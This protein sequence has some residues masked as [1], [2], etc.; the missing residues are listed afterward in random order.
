MLKRRLIALIVLLLGAGIGWFVYSSQ[1]S[2][3]RPFKLGLDLSGGTQ[4]IYRAK[5]DAIQG[6]SVVDSMAS[7]RDTIERR[8]NLF[9][10]SE[11][12]VQTEHGGTLAGTSEERLIVELPGITDTEKA[13]TL[14]GQT[15]VLEFRMLK[16]GVTPPP[17]GAALPNAN[18]LFEPAAIT[19][20]HLTSAQIQFNQNPGGIPNE[21]V[22]ALHF[23]AEGGKIFAD[24]TKNN[25]GRYFG[26]FLDGVPISIPVI[27]E[28]IPDGTAIISGN[29]TAVEAKEL[30]RNLSFGALPVPIELIGAQTV[31]GTLGGEA[32]VRGILAG[33]WG[34]GLVGFFMIIWYRLPGVVSVVALMLYVAVILALFKLIPVTLTA[35]GIAAFILSV[36]MAV[37]ANILIFERT[38]EEM[39]NGKSAA[40][41]IH[42]GF[43]R[44]WP[45]IRDSNISSMI[46]AV[47]LFWFGTSL[48]K[49][50]A[51]VFGLGVLVSM[52]TAITV[53]RTFLLAL[54]INAK[55]G[56]TR[57]LFG[58]GV[59]S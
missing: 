27:R 54:G 13:I 10:V 44:A 50:F 46:T 48:I 25:V 36:G 49:G 16:V 47:I 17:S 8:V 34:I 59:K 35:A 2:G 57:F 26:M 7:L 45:S 18:E 29:F 33:L 15:P 51:L 52:L 22:V 37:D 28:S 42:D 24:L 40:E 23:N 6:S 53:S 38:K 55:T 56:F 4:L 20:R 1:M 31:S 30:A 43:A 19:G 9:G 32:V 5:L 39:K 12:I 11:P 41:A 58:G 21:P 3:S 14:I